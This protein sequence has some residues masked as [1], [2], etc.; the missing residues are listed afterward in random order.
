MQNFTF[1]VFDQK[2]VR[3][4]SN[5]GPI[6]YR[7]LTNKNLPGKIFSFLRIVASEKSDF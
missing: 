3:Y 2:T 7:Y 6:F 4:R 1:G 5:V